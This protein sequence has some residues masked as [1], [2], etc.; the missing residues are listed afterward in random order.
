MI[1][2]KALDMLTWAYSL[3]DI[4]LL[5]L[6]A[7]SFTIYFGYQKVTKDIRVSFS[8]THSK[9]YDTHITNLVLSN[10]RDNA[11]AISSIFVRIGGKG[12]F[13]LVSFSEPLVIKAYDTQLVDV[14]K[15]T[16]LLGGV[17]V[18]EIDIFDDLFFNIITVSGDVIECHVES[19]VNKYG[20][21][22]RLV[23]HTVNFDDIV[24]TDRMAY[25]FS[26]CIDGVFK[27]IIIDKHGFISGH[28]PFSINLFPSLSTES[29]REFLIN[30]GFHDMF[31][32]YY[33]V[34]VDGSL[35]TYVELNKTIVNNYIN[36]VRK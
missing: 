35:R 27:K 21:E 24:L 10:K 11:L 31:S 3:F 23:K 13:E 14:P 20:L 26:Y 29:F 4:K 28:S 1:N 12:N 32:N 25:I 19:A 33:L 17:G 18:V 30:R 5:T 8:M 7:A 22:D 36:S 2:H 34:R 15:Y 6:I 16:C 9:L